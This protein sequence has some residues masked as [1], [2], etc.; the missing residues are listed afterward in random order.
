MSRSGYIKKKQ[1]IQILEQLNISDPLIIETL[2]S[3]FDPQKT[4]RFDS[5]EFICGLATLSS[6]ID[7]NYKLSLLF[8]CYDWEGSGNLGE[9]EILKLL[10]TVMK[11]QKKKKY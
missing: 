9:S 5:R 4:G 6:N 3:T 11:T 2:V 7:N 1:F 8:K 10:Q